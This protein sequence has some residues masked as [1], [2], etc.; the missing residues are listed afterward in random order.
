MDNLNAAARS[1]TMAAIKSSGTRSTERRLRAFLVGHGI[2]GWGCQALDLPGKPDFIFNHEQVAVFA[3]GCF[4]HACPQCCRMPQTNLIYWQKKIGANAARDRRISGELSA[5]G[6]RVLRFWE[7]EIREDPLG[8]IRRIDKELKRD[9][10]EQLGL[11]ISG[12][13]PVKP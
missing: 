2:R 6:W 1:Q 3:D 7:H 12:H 4:W 9:V 5:L 11:D 8:V 13:Y 10:G